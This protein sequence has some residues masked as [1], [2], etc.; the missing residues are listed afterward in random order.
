VIAAEEARVHEHVLL[1]MH[2]TITAE[3]QATRDTGTI[4]AIDFKT[5]AASFPEPNIHRL[6]ILQN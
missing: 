5:I 6:N 4:T 3:V 2:D 1:P